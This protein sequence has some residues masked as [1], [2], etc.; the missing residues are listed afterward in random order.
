MKKT[1]LIFIIIFTSQIFAQDTNI[2]KYFPLKVGNVW[3]YDWSL[4]GPFP[5]SGH[6][7]I[8]VFNS[9]VV[10]G[11]VYYSLEVIGTSSYCFGSDTYSAYLISLVN[12]PFRVD[13]LSGN[14]MVLNLSCGAWNIGERVFDSLKSKLHDTTHCIASYCYDTSDISVFGISSKGKKFT[15]IT[16]PMTPYS[17]YFAKNFGLYGSGKQ[18]WSTGT[19]SYSLVGCLIDGVLYGDTT[20]PVGLKQ[21]ETEIPESFSLS[22]NYPN[23]FNP[24]TVIRFQVA[25]EELVKITV[26]NVLGKEVSVLV[27]ENLKPG[28]Y[29]TNWDGSNIQAGLLL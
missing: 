3:V 8:S 6:Q 4:I 18:C 1:L 16:N 11:H 19:L 10:N 12:H 29:E 22:Q 13:S 9:T 26:Y 17:H 7:R 24:N 14:I 20:F 21:V 23:P 27:N 2:V 25:S 28:I 5:Q 15:E